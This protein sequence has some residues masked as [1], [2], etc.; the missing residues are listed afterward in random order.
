MP[1]KSESIKS[2]KAME[3]INMTEQNN[4]YL[5][6]G[7]LA[8][9][10]AFLLAGPLG[11]CWLVGGIDRY[12]GRYEFEG[13]IKE[14]RVRFEQVERGYG[15]P[16]APGSYKLTVERNGKIVEYIDAWGR[17]HNIDYL[18][19]ISN[20][21]TNIIYNNAEGAKAFGIGQKQFE[22]YLSEIEKRKT[23]EVNLRKMKEKSDIENKVKENIELIK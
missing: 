14:E 1:S 8:I 11:L 18:K 6:F 17:D 20:V 4:S 13:K 7:A 12:K 16:R 19:V 5:N 15:Y 9:T 10:F 22:F 21:Q 23:E 3:K 2:L